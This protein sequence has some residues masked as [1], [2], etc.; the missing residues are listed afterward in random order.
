MKLLVP[1]L[2]KEIVAHG[3]FREGLS[4]SLLAAGRL[5]PS[6]SIIN[7]SKDWKGRLVSD[8]GETTRFVLAIGVI[9]V[10]WRAMNQPVH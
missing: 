9:P 8:Q 5:F 6:Y 7:D 2:G 3:S 1:H 10:G 4:I